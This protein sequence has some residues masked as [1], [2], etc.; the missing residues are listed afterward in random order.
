MRLKLFSSLIAVCAVVMAAGCTS[1]LN[2]EEEIDLTITV[3]GD[4]LSLPVGTTEQFRI[5]DFLNPD[6]VE[7]LFVDENGNYF[8]ELSQTFEEQVS[9]SD[10]AED[11]AVEGI[12]QTFGDKNYSV[13]EDLYDASR[14]D[15]A[16]SV[17]FDFDEQFTYLFSLEDA[18]DSGL[19]SIRSVYLEDTYMVPRVHISSDKPI[20]ASLTMS[21]DIVVPDKYSF[22]A[23]PSVN[24]NIVSYEGSVNS[25]GDVEFAPVALDSIALNLEEGDPFEFEDSFRVD[26]MSI[27]IDGN[28]AQAFEG[29]SLT[30]SSSVSAGAEDGKMHPREFYGKVDIHLDEV[31]NQ[32]E[33][34]DIPEYLKNEDV[35]LDF[36][37]PYATVSL[38][39]NAGVPFL[40]DATVEPYSASGTVSPIDLTLAAP[41][42]DDEA[43]QE[44]LE[45]WLS[46]ENAD[47][48]SGYQW[49]EADIRSLLSRIPDR[50]DVMINTYSDLSREEDQYINCHA[51]YSFDGEIKFV[52]PFAFGENLYVP[53]R[54]TMPNVPV[55]IGQALTNADVSVNGSITNTFPMAL[56]VSGYFLDSNYGKLDITLGTQ[57]VESAGADGAPVT[58]PLN[59]RVNKSPV[60]EQIA[61]FVLELELLAG[62]DPGV[63]ISE[64]SWVQAELEFGIPGGLTLDLN[65]L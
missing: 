39:T 21:L 15:E 37:S 55:E 52:L 7:Y 1:E 56:N 57:R 17:E 36:F 50:L 9:V 41:V 60:A 38:T 24:G 13:P 11:M 59:I 25:E 26:N 54:D 10:Y 5:S 40:I 45:Y 46:S 44:T 42:S 33:L 22:E 47:V 8:L 64:N 31:V 19:V 53:V 32:F 23:S 34:T 30:V 3:G 35:Y 4:S 14:P 58:S 12:M 48:P 20:P 2:L 62:Q 28:Q 63:D 65:N 43:V 6:S 29:A 49:V 27:S 18:K 16:V 51:Q 61:Y